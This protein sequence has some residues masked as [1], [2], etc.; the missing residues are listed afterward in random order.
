MGNREWLERVTGINAEYL[1]YREL[2]EQ[3]FKDVGMQEV[4]QYIID[5]QI[6]EN[7]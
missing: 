7:E 5:R 1:N 4:Y 2:L 6:Y 3:I